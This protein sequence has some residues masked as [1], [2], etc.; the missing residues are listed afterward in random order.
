MSS[1]EKETNLNFLQLIMIQIST[2]ILIINNI[3]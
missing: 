2:L 1:A 3:I